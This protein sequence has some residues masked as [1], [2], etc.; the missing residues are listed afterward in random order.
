LTEF[1][2]SDVNELLEVATSKFL[3]TQSIKVL[4]SS[5]LDSQEPDKFSE[6]GSPP[7]KRCRL[8]DN[9]SLEDFLMTY[10]N[11]IETPQPYSWNLANPSS[12]TVNSF[13]SLETKEKQAANGLSKSSPT[14]IEH[15]INAVGHPTILKMITNQFIRNVTSLPP[16]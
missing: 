6:G 1:S 3:E 7:N 10:S 15:L 5:E 16:K 11:L 9:Y 4:A 14:Y 8:S 12:G 2:E 13:D